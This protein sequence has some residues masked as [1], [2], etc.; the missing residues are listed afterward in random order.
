MTVIMAINTAQVR[1]DDEAKDNQVMMKEDRGIMSKGTISRRDGDEAMKEE[2][3]GGNAAEI[4]RGNDRTEEGRKEVGGD[5]IGRWKVKRAIRD[6]ENRRRRHH[7]GRQDK[8]RRTLNNCAEDLRRDRVV[9]ALGRL[10]ERQRR[11][12]RQADNAGRKYRMATRRRMRNDE[13]EDNRG[14][15]SQEKKGKGIKEGKTAEKYQTIHD[16]TEDEVETFELDQDRG[17]QPRKKI[18]KDAGSAKDKIQED[19]E[20]VDRS[21]K[22]REERGDFGSTSGMK[23]RGGRGNYR[24]RGRAGRGRGQCNRGRGGSEGRRVENEPALVRKY[25]KTLKKRIQFAEEA[26]CENTNKDIRRIIQHLEE[27]ATQGQSGSEMEDWEYLLPDLGNTRG[28]M[29]LYK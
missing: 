26:Y 13:D 11:W 20:Q 6:E 2:A 15:R 21:N 27:E 29:T 19:R 18:W 14:R 7:K 17:E 9:K 16:D 24:K 25:K 23:I 4:G 28:R 12:R 22:W 10:I 8:Q 1:D 3:S 5:E